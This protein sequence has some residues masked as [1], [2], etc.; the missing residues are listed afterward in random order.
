MSAS[1]RGVEQRKH[2]GDWVDRTRAASRRHSRRAPPPARLRDAG[3][4]TPAV[5][6]RRR[7]PSQT[8]SVNR[9]GSYRQGRPM[10]RWPAACPWRGTSSADMQRHRN[11]GNPVTADDHRPLCAACSSAATR[12]AQDA[13]GQRRIV[14]RAITAVRWRFGLRRPSEVADFMHRIDDQQ[15][16]ACRRSDRRQSPCRSPLQSSA[17]TTAGPAEVFGSADDGFGKRADPRTP[18]NHVQSCPWP[19]RT[20]AQV[21]ATIVRE[22]KARDQQ[23]PCGGGGAAQVVVGAAH[24]V[25]DHDFAIDG[26]ADDARSVEYV[27]R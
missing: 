8:C 11:A 4:A 24:Q 23:R 2:A 21:S 16:P 18:R 6:C 27:N 25:D 26:L 7:A 9:A 13:A 12:V 20:L 22:G 10:A 3:P 5:R 1:V 14:H 15:M 19:R 17:A